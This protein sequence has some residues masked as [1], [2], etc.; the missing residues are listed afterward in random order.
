V[1]QSSKEKAFK[2]QST[3]SEIAILNPFKQALWS[4]L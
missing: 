3:Y 1:E 2:K 4:K